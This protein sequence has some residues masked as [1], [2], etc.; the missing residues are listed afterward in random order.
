MGTWV[1]IIVVATAVTMAGTE[2]TLIGT[3]GAS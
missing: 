1:L 2:A 3:D